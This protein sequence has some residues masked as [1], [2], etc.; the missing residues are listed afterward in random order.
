MAQDEDPFDSLTHEDVEELVSW[1]S[2]RK[3]GIEHDKDKERNASMVEDL[4]RMKG[5]GNEEQDSELGE[6]DVEDLV[7]WLSRRRG[8]SGS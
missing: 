5:N 4:S 7:S 2:S 1:V 3:R 6:S 8:T